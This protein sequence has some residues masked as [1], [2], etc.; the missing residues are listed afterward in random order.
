MKRHVLVLA[1]F[2]IA[3]TAN[4]FAQKFIPEPVSEFVPYRVA[5]AIASDDQ[6]EILRQ[7]EKV[8][9]NDSLYTGLLVSKSSALIE[10]ERYDEAIE[11]CNEG[12]T[13]SHSENEADFYVNKGVCYLRTEDYTKALENFEEALKSY[14]KNYLLLYNRGV[15]FRGL[16]RHGEAA[17]SYQEAIICHP[18]HAGSHLN[19]GLICMQQNLLSQAMM[20]FNTYLILNPDG[21]RSFSVLSMYNSLMSEKY[22]EEMIEMDEPFKDSE[23]FEEID[24]LISN[25]ASLSKSYKIPNKIN[26]ALVKQNHAMMSQLKNF[27]GNDGFWDRYYVP[28]HKY[29]FDNGLFNS[30]TYTVCFSVENTKYK[31]M[32]NKKISDIRDFIGNYSSQCQLTFGSGE[33]ENGLTPFTVY[34]NKVPVA[35]GYLKNEMPEGEWKFYSEKGALRTEGFFEEGKK[36][37]FWKRYDANGNL[38]ETNNFKNDELEGETRLYHSN[39]ALHR[40]INLKEG[41]RHGELK[42]Y[43]P[44]GA[45]IDVSI[46]DEGELTGVGIAYHRRGSESKEYEVNYVDGEVDGKV[47]RYYPD[48]K[49]HEERSYKEGLPHGVWKNYFHS[50]KIYAEKEFDEGEPSG[51]YTSYFESGQIDETGSYVDG[52]I[53]GVW[54]SYFSDGTLYEETTFDKGDRVKNK[55]FR[56]TGEILNEYDYTRGNIVAYRYFDKEGNV[57]HENKKKGGEFFHEGFSGNGNKYSEGLYD[58]NGGKVGDWKFYATDG[59]LKTKEFRD[60]DVLTKIERYHEN[61]KLRQVEP[62]DGDTLSGHFKSYYANEKMESQGWYKHDE[63]EGEWREYYADGTLKRIEYYNNGKL[64]G[65]VKE[66]GVDGKLYMEYVYFNGDFETERYFDAEGNNFLTNNILYKEK[67]TVLMA[68]YA[69]GQPKNVFQMKHGVKDGSYKNY[70]FDGSLRSEGSY[71]NGQETGSWKWYHE[72]GKL[73]TEGQYVLGERHGTWKSYYDNGKLKDERTYNYGTMTGNRKEFNDKGVMIRERNYDV[74]GSLHGKYTFY[75]EDGKVQ[76][77]RVY[78]FGTLIGWT[79]EGPDGKLKELT[80][81][82]NNTAEIEATFRNGKVSRKYTMLNGDFQGTYEEYYSTGQIHDVQSY[83][84]GFTQGE[85]K[86]YYIDGTL[87]QRTQYNYGEI[88]GKSEH[89]HSNGKLKE[90]IQYLNDER[91][92]SYKKY[93]K[94]GKLILERTYFNG[95]IVSEKKY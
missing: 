5:E 89:F 49:I 39:G 80:P 72:N 42:E 36:S 33:E 1:A 75:S 20:C 7:I 38:T 35:I 27:E 29:I 64:F 25:F 56:R 22:D 54:Y 30:Y 82:K 68:K 67:D 34:E 78:E 70:F 55:V 53:D 94:T 92:G 24:L 63:R 3:V 23:S 61:G 2:L 4:S 87:K 76:L 52:E 45:L 95:D 66:F 6:M 88:H 83:E 71:L 32:V 14:P 15:A 11:V 50:G 21:P 62:Y 51:K 19:L 43:S 10:L 73:S 65:T 77:V 17:K 85:Y 79:C 26:L 58:V 47:T 91:N 84:N 60:D 57:F 31:K 44:A 69:N 16:E 59:W 18:T 8:P 90:E 12:L 13:R 74:D 86:A 48:G 46:Y 93:D 40:L 28:L 41:K 81:I 9:E 37:G